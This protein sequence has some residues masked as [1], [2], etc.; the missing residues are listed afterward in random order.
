VPLLGRDPA[1]RDRPIRTGRRDKPIIQLPSVALRVAVV[2][3]VAAVMFGI[4]FF[5]LW[6]LQILSG[7]EFVAQANDNRLKSVTIAAPRGNIVD[8]NGKVIVTTRGGEYVGIRLMDVPQ[9]QLEQELEQLAP[10]LKMKPGK[11][12]QE[13]L[14]Y[15]KPSTF[16]LQGGKWVSFLTWDKV[17]SG[18]ITGID[19]IPLKEDVSKRI[20]TYVEEHT[21]SYPG[22]EV[23]DEYLR[24]YPNG[25]LAAHLLGHVGPISA[26][27]LKTQ[28]FKGYSGGDVVGYDGLE[29]TYDKWLRGR[30]GVAKVEVDAQGRPKAGAV[31]PGGRMAQPG[32]TLVTTIDAKVQ[33]AAQK[34]LVEGINLA[35]SNGEYDANG[36]AAVVLDVKSGDVLAM[37]SYPTYNPTIWVGGISQKDYNR[38][39][40]RKSQNYP[41]LNRATQETKA[42]GSTFKAV[43]A[44]A[45]LEE[46]VISTGTTQWCPGYY[47]SPHDTSHQ[48]FYCWAK[49]G[50]G[51]L[52]LIGAITQSCDTYFYHVGDLFYA[53]PGQALEDWAKRLGFGRLTGIDI[54]FEA[55]GRVPTPGWKK[56]WPGFKTE[57]DR[58]WKPSDSMYLAV[59]QGNLE[60]TPL[61]LATAYAAIAN[62]GKMVTPHLGL[63]IVDPAG[64]TVRSLE[65][66]TPAPKVDISQETLDAVRRGLYEAAHNPAGTSAPVFY[67]YKVDVSGKTGTA[68]VWD[69]AANRMVN[70]AWYA[71]YAPSNDPK[72]A[73]VVMIEKGGHGATTAAPATRMIYDSLFHIDSG[74]FSGNVNGD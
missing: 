55:P 63:R 72:Y 24:S 74:S 66:T 14:A 50:H 22:V 23:Q 59:G 49:S 15:L 52:D 1:R 65:P 64:Q 35:H 19:L 56:T 10:H 11:L 51:T 36:G 37:A 7:Q 68:E 9:G 61:Q 70:Y 20:R 2:I 17:V 12:R 54:P 25:D 26:E 30:D 5:R 43:T 69:A 38:T 71:S 46:G 48:K 53:R 6:F 58:L 28:H 33:D 42:V 47:I 13:I 4:V 32:D 67:D 3:G 29:W 40:V 39:F 57:I 60:A 41:Q 18:D 62:G 44:I 8:R 31:V 73:V 34:A 27:Q 45:G 16:E 21:P